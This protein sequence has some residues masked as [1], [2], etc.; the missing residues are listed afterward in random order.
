MLEAPWWDGRSSELRT[1]EQLAAHHVA[2]LLELQPSGPYMLAGSSFGGLL[3][4]EIARQLAA[5]GHEIALLVALDTYA[6]LRD[7]GHPRNWPRRPPT[8]LGHSIPERPWMLLRIVRFRARMIRRTT[9]HVRWR[10]LLWLDQRRFGAIPERHRATYVSDRTATAGAAY[11]PLPYDGRVVLFRCTSYHWPEADRGWRA[12]A[13]GGLEIHDVACRHGEE[14]TPPFVQHF[15]P[16]LAKVIRDTSSASGQSSDSIP[17][18]G[19]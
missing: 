6:G 10:M 7:S 2:E 13:R 15:A 18:A 17:V 5:C 11:R 14:L 16:R 4:L 19:R 1:I 12:L 9:A 3:A 8:F